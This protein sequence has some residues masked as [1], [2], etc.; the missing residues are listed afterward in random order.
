MNNQRI[1]SLC[2]IAIIIGLLALYG[3]ASKEA[4]PNTSLEELIEELPAD[5]QIPV[6][7]PTLVD[8][9]FQPKHLV[10]APRYKYKVSLMTSYSDGSQHDI[11]S[12]I[13][14]EHVEQHEL[15]LISSEP[16]QITIDERG[17]VHIS[18]EAFIGQTAT[19]SAHYGDLSAQFDVTVSYSLEDTVVPSATGIGVVTNPESIAVVVNKERSLPDDFEPDDLVKP[20]V[21]FSFTGE[22]ERRYLRREAAEALERLF[23]QA[24]EDG[25]NITAV[26]GY[27]TFQTQRWLFNHYVSIDGEEEARRYSAYPG[28]SE[29]QTGLTM[30][31]SSP[32]I[33][34]AI[35]SEANF[36]DTVE[37]M[38]L[39][40]NVAQYGFIIRYPEGKEH[41][42]GYVYEPWHIRYVGVPLAQ[43]LTEH[44]ITLEEY[45]A[46]AIPVHQNLE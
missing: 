36:G 13:K 45:F 31:V 15:S 33:N 7:L 26:S 18:E 25:I 16:A 9:T 34:N 21:P 38:W 8:M 35:S 28:T 6:D 5:E 17:I 19:I 4:E 29:H 43:H 27:R 22:N 1:T 10:L 37:G 2:F 32:S 3:C 12:D 42:T 24:E 30:D 40:D 23:A 39:A 41:I 44:G 20:N 11:L 14:P 46:E